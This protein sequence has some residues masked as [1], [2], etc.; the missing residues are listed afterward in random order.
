MF[1]KIKLSCENEIFSPPPGLNG[2]KLVSVC[3]KYHYVASI[4]FLF[5]RRL[6]LTLTGNDWRM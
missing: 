2:A 1:K 4:H 3:L 6:L 5:C